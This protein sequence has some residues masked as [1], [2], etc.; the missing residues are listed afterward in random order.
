LAQLA[1]GQE[2][3]PQQAAA[4]RTDAPQA[5]TAAVPAGVIGIDDFA[6]IELRAALV[7]GCEAVAG[8]EK[9]L[10]LTL[11]VGGEE[12]QV[13]SGIAKWYGPG[14]LVGRK[15]ALVYNLKPAKLRGV[16]S[17][18]MILAADADGAASVVLL[19]D[20]VPSGAKIH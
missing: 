19:D 15:I 20:K 4:A 17:Q 13:V 6:K 16:E 5:H 2:A 12:R 14:Q 3:V 9:L 18:G 10:R 1:D 7:T 8:S 11:D